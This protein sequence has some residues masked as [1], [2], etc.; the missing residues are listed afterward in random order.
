MLRLCFCLAKLLNI[1]SFCYCHITLK[2]CTN[3]HREKLNKAR[4]IA[5]VLFEVLDTVTN[6]A[7]SQVSSCCCLLIHLFLLLLL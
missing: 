4:A 6:A 3:F 5:S 7:G 2:L 1:T